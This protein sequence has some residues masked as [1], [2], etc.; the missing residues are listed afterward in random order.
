MPANSS[1]GT[2][3]GISAAKARRPTRA[4]PG[5]AGGRGGEGSQIRNMRQSAITAAG[6]TPAA[7]S[8]ATDSD[9]TDPSTSIARLGGRHS[10]MAA[11]DPTSP[12]D[13][14]TSDV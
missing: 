12:P 14:S 13:W 11:E 1:A 5:L 2:D 6:S 9:V 8:A 10:P 4:L 3:S 7:K